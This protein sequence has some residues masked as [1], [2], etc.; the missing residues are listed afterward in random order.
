VRFSSSATVLLIAFWLVDSAGAQGAIT[1]PLRALA[2]NPNYFA[3]DTGKA[4]YLTG[5]HTWNNLQDWRNG[6]PIQPFDFTAYVNM[7]VAH[8]HNFTLLWRSELPTFCGMPVAANSSV[9]FTVSPHPWQRVGP[10]DA[11]DGGLRFDLTKFNES[12]FDRL[13]SRVQQLNASGIYAGIYL[14]T[15]EWLN[16]FRC[17]GDGY[18]FTGSNNVNGIDDGGGIGSMTMTAPNVITAIQDAF[19]D[20]MIDTLNDLPNVLWIV[21]EESPA[22][23]VWWNSHLIAHVRSHEATKPLQHPIGYGDSVIADSAVYDSDAD[24]VA[25]SVRISPTRTCGSGVPPCKVNINDSDHS[26]FGM[27]NDTAE[28]NR[29]YVWKN[30]LSGNHVL[31]MDPYE[32]YYP[33]ENRNLCL[34]PVNGVCSASDSRWDNLRDNLGYTRAYADRVNLGAMTPQ[35][36]LFSNGYGLANTSTSNAEYLGYTSSGS[37]LRIDLR[38]TPGTL[39]LEWFNP[40]TGATLSGGTIAGGT[41]QTLTAPFSDDAV[42][43][44]R[45][46]PPDN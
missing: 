33:R 4:V 16:A 38:A 5:S 29:A 27:W 7:L 15:G 6:G 32:I 2:S 20:K 44:L 26:Y 45:S 30:F 1:V 9:N 12:F 17:S 8:G 42:V 24:W 11:S 18:P 10:G 28:Q 25:P 40:S 19:V 3:D 35:G 46:T 37:P 36:K 14:F 22:S 41:S 21:S 23:S 31:F 43:Y 39:S 13:R 34:L